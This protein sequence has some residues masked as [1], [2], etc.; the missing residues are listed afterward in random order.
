MANGD[1]FDL[2]F[3]YVKETE[4]PIIF[5]R[6]SL[7]SGVAAWL[8]RNAW[9]PFGA[10]RIFPNQYIMLVGNPGSRKSTAIKGVKKILS[11]SGYTT[12]SAEKTT[13][14]KFLVDLEGDKDAGDKESILN[15]FGDNTTFGPPREVFIPADEFNE[16]TGSGNI[17]FLS[18]LGNFWDWDD[19]NLPYKSRVKT[20]KS[21]EIYQPTI[22]ILAGNTHAGF[23]EAF[24][25]AVLGQ[26]FMSR[27]VLVYGESSGKR[28]T[29]PPIPDASIL[30]R[31][32]REL[33][34]IK[35]KVSGELTLSPNAFCS[36][37]RSTE[38]GKI[39]RITDSNTTPP[40]DLPT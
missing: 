17:E 5:H 31:I 8:G 38:L 18:L 3:Q 16:F 15:L 4:S 13:K 10:G 1:L 12:F 39:L 32:I 6:W 20:S 21:V 24:P 26:G 19:P 11:Q 29:I 36:L 33:G 35:S 14:E 28:I 23:A 22:N 37:T 7:I 27:L 30:E 2:Y 25:V 34:E 40:D 9:L